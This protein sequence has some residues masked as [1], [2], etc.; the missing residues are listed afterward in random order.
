VCLRQSNGP[1]TQKC[2][3]KLNP[4]AGSTA[5]WHIQA[6]IYAKKYINYEQSQR[7]QPNVSKAT[8]EAS[9]LLLLCYKRNFIK[10]NE[11]A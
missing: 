1:G 7:G 11:Y 3:Q 10:I 8:S 9:A 6:E 4:V 5:I 2:G